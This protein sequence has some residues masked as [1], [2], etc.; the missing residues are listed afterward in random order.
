MRARASLPRCRRARTT[1]RPPSAGGGTTSP[2]AAFRERVLVTPSHPH[3]PAP[4]PSPLDVKSSAITDRA[5]RPPTLSASAPRG[6]SVAPTERKMPYRTK[7][8][9]S[10]L[11][12]RNSSRSLCILSTACTRMSP[13][14]RPERSRRSTAALT[15]TRAAPARTTSSASSSATT[16]MPPRPAPTALRSG[17]TPGLPPTANPWTTG[18]C[19]F[20]PGR[21]WRGL[22]RSRIARRLSATPTSSA[23]RRRPSC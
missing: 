19:L 2:D 8:I 6:R 10:R 12:G 1:R 9:S 17:T 22:H 20:A 3:T 7:A 13:A 14:H 15:A 21:P 11:S 16:C 4:R 5:T 18:E 23:S